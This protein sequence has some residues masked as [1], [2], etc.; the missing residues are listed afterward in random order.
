MLNKVSLVMLVTIASI[1]TLNLIQVLEV[2]EYAKII[3][4]YILGAAHCLVVALI[5]RMEEE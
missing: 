4:A 2:S 3:K 5:S 1:L